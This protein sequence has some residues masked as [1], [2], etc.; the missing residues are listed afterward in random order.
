M[1]CILI[2]PSL[3]SYYLIGVTSLTE[4]LNAN[5]FPPS[6]WVLFGGMSNMYWQQNIKYGREGTL[7]N[8]EYFVVGDIN[9]G[10]KHVI[11]IYIWKIMWSCWDWLRRVGVN[12]DLDQKL[13]FPFSI[14]NRGDL[15]GNGQYCVFYMILNNLD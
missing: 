3:K 11:Y 13:L 6:V 8:T 12:F 1:Q 10:R 14:N 15:V 9:R 4:I 7:N 2:Y 5:T